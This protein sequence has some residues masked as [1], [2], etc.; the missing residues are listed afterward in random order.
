MFEAVVHALFVAMAALAGWLA[1]RHGQNL[2]PSRD[3]TRRALKQAGTEAEAIGIAL[4]R[5]AQSGVPDRDMLNSLALQALDLADHVEAMQGDA[6]VRPLQEAQTTLRPLLDE[7]L[8]LARSQLGQALPPCRID[9]S[10]DDVALFVDAR[11]LRGAVTQVLTRAARLAA[12]G[13]AIALRFTALGGMAAIVIEDEN[14]TAGGDL[15]TAAPDATR[16]IGFGL[17]LARSLLRAHGGD[18]VMETAPGIGTRAWLTLP[19]AR[20][21]ANVQA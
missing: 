8:G 17:G 10:V 14:G 5:Q 19:I 2:L 15:A 20:L 11:A 1:A 21:Y 3:A 18:L 16:G 4:R 7:A 9:A 12:P 13:D 6:R